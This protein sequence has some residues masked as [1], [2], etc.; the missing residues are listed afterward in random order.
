MSMRRLILTLAAIAAL[1]PASALA[2]HSVG[3][4]EQVAW[5][6]RA[7]T[8]FLN[9]ELSGNG[10]GACGILIAQLRATEH[11][12][13]C[14]QRWNAKLTRLLHQP[15]ERARLQA[16]QRAISSAVVIVH[17][18]NAWLHLHSR[19]I[20]GPNRFEWTENCWMLS[21]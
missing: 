21:G 11:Q 5:V 14:A 10:A 16:Q 15:G 6:R 2:S 19:L 8:N 3:S 13:S 12:R 9:A 17:G 20:S 4:A 7:A 1:A 18:N